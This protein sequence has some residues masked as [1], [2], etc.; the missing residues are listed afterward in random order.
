V[1]LPHGKKPINYKWVYKIK[2]KAYGSL[3][4]CKAKA[5]IGG[6]TQ[7]E[8][9]DYNETLSPVVKMATVRCLVAT[10][11]KKKWPIIN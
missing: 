11:A 7:K 3:E 8:G 4:R 9:I 1:P 2:Y 6:F 10:A 5:V